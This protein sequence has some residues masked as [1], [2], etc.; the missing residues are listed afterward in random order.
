MRPVLCKYIYGSFW[1]KT[2]ISILTRA[3]LI[4]LRFIGDI[5][6]LIWTRCKEQIIWN[7]DELNTK[8]NSIKF[9]HKL[10]K[11]SIYFLDTEVCLKHN[12]L[13]TK[14]C[15]KQTDRQS[16]LYINSEDK[17]LLKNSI[18]YSQT[19]PIKQICTPSREF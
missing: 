13:H 1:K 7:L 2:Y 18:P 11:T 15:R 3:F 8:Q 19:L 10:S 16:F 14:I 9:E 5:L 12:K 17:K 4:Y 6:L